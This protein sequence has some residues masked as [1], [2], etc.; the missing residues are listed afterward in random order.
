MYG[1]ILPLPNTPSPCGAQLKKKSTGITLLLP[2]TYFRCGK[3]RNKSSKHTY[4]VFLKNALMKVLDCILFV[5]NFVAELDHS[6][7]TEKL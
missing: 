6:T 5:W 3:T 2:F 1:A 7:S 4:V